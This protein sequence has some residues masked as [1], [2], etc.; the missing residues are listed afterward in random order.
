MIIGL[1]AKH[2]GLIQMLADLWQGMGH[3]VRLS[4]LWPGFSKTWRGDEDII[5]STLPY[6]KE[7]LT[8]GKPTI[9][10]YTDPTF[11]YLQKN[12]QDLF[13]AKAIQVIGAEDCYLPEHF[14]QG[15]TRFIPFAVNPKEYPV[16][17]PDRNEVI[18]VNRKPEERWKEVIR[19]ATGVYMDLDAYLDG[20]P[21]RVVNDT[22]TGSF[23]QNYARSKVLFYFSNS[24]YTLVM[25]EA[26]TVGMPI[27]AFN[28]HHAA[29]SHP[30]EKY[31]NL[32]STD[33]DHIRS[34]LRRFLELD[35]EHLR[36]KYP[37]LPSFDVVQKMWDYAFHFAP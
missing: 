33:R 2:A 14:P 19:G 30:I 35:G 27:V 10:Y 5:V 25:F 11:P 8:T 31:L 12:V 17:R 18:V 26:M 21:Y 36:Q 23:R 22:D 13:D 16:Y 7:S 32:Y 34:L 28:H 9:V 24:P 29:K 3:E 1:Y 20:I 6:D 4:P 15:V 37:A